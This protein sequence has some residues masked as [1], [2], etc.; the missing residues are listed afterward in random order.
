MSSAGMPSRLRR[1]LVIVFHG[2]GTIIIPVGSFAGL[3]LAGVI[4]EGCAFYNHC[5]YGENLLT[6]ALGLIW[7]VL[8]A[9]CIGLGWRGRL[10]GARRKTLGR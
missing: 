10:Y 3:T 1:I 5:S 8:I 9:A 7:V 2:L 4:S 6:S